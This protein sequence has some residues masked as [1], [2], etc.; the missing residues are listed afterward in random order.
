MYIV[1]SNNFCSTFIIKHKA[2]VDGHFTWNHIQKYEK[3]G[4]SL[5]D[6]RNL[7]PRLL[8]PLHALGNFAVP[9]LSK[10]FNNKP[11]KN[12]PEHWSCPVHVPVGCVAGPPATLDYPLYFQ[13]CHAICRAVTGNWMTA[14]RGSYI[15]QWATC[16]AAAGTRAVSEALVFHAPI[17]VSAGD[18][19]VKDI[20]WRIETGMVLSHYIR[21][22]EVTSGKAR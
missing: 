19:P 3:L 12:W 8:D 16:S 18:S 1:W 21:Q 14:E 9:I 6:Q 2:L 13:W 11:T 17:Q 20:S 7:K 10:F 4:H 15:C 22:N 5:I